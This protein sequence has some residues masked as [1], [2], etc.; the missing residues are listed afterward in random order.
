M[1][2]SLNLLTVFRW[3]CCRRQMI[4]SR[5]LGL[6]SRTGICPTVRVSMLKT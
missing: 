3:R 1:N 2:E 5:W 6:V 4:V